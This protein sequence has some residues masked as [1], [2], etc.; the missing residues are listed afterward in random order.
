MKKRKK[1]I[2]K[3]TN[4]DL[5]IILF[6]Y[7]TI[8]ILILMLPIIYKILLPVTLYPV[9]YILRLFFDS[10]LVYNNSYVVDFSYSFVLI[11]ACIAGSAYLL[12]IGLNLAMKMDYKKRLYSILTTVLLLYILNIL[13][14]VVFSIIYVNG[15]SYFDFTHKLFWY[16]LSTVYV[17]FIW[18]FSVKIFKI[19]EIPVISD[20]KE[21]SKYIKFKK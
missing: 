4:L 1:K 2:L 16:V 20:F 9:V 5:F 8:L 15:F 3:K 17:V 7:L 11:N 21:L 6:R 18:F 10:V 13:R 14:I 19:H 12:L